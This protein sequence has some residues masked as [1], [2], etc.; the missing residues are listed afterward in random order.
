MA[1]HES[2]EVDAPKRI[3]FFKP[4][5]WLGQIRP[6][7]RDEAWS[8]SLWQTFFAMT[9][10]AQ[11]SVIAE[12]P[13]AVIASGLWLQSFSLM[14]WETISVLVPLIRVPKRLMT[15]RLSNWLTFSAL[16]IQPRRNTTLLKAGLGHCGDIELAAYLAANAAGPV[17]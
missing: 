7:C 14:R 3:L 9:M 16:R 15:G 12:K 8:V 11:I 4:M 17:P 6:H 13:L 1:G 10:G 5:S 2:Q